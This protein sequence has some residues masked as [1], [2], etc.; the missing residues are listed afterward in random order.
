MGYSPWGG[1]ES[2]RT[3]QLSAHTHTSINRQMEKEDVVCTHILLSYNNAFCNNI[4]RYGGYYAYRNKNQ[5]RERQIPYVISYVW[6]LKN[7]WMYI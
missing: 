7:K 3:E 2:D 1:K 5:T 4:D 6:K